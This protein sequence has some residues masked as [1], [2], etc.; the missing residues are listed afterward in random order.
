[1]AI[2]PLE[3]PKNALFSKIAPKQ[4]YF[5]PYSIKGS[6]LEYQKPHVEDGHR[7]LAWRQKWR[8]VIRACMGVA[9][10]MRTDLYPRWFV[11]THQWKI[12]RFQRN[13]SF[14]TGC[15]CRC[16]GELLGLVFGIA[17]FYYSPS[18]WGLFYFCRQKVLPLSA[19]TL[20]D[21]IFMYYRVLTLSELV[22]I[23]VAF[24]LISSL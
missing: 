8:A 10:C 2:W 1:M 16:W 13:L 23:F 12:D 6:W 17:A 21:F 14:F 15:C 22:L 11:S 24:S 19:D 3:H 20:P 5:W 9:L 4:I 7:P 18:F